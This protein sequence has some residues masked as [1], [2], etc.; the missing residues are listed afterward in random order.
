[1]IRN[2]PARA[3]V[4]FALAAA[5]FGCGRKKETPGG[6][7]ASTGAGNAPGQA[8]APHSAPQPGGA[9]GCPTISGEYRLQ[10]KTSC[11]STGWGWVDV[12][13]N[14]CDITADMRQLAVIKGRLE[15]DS[16]NVALTFNYPCGGSGSGLLS[17][18]GRVVSGTFS[19]TV[20]GTELKCCT[21]QS[22][23]F[24]FTKQ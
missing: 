8:P 18:S 9:T 11:G 5:L 1:M 12:V 23:T 17:V 20:T 4:A 24:T 15:G 7:P 22:G 14:G 16:A 13:Q 10:F 19:A 21:P 3:L 6:A 2:R